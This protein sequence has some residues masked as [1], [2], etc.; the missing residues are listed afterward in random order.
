MPELTFEHT[1]YY[2]TEAAIPAW[3]VAESLLALQALATRSAVAIE[4]LFPDVQVRATTVYVEQLTSGS[5]K[6]LVLIKLLFG[7]QKRLEKAVDTAR[8]AIGLDTLGT[9]HPLLA[10]LILALALDGCEIAVKYWHEK[11][12]LPQI[13]VNQMIIVNAGADALSIPPQVFKAAVDAAAAHNSANLANDA[14]RF[15]QPAKSGPSG[16]LELQESPQFAISPETVQLMPSHILPQPNKDSLRDYDNVEVEIRATDLD[17]TKSGWWVRVP[18]IS[19]K[20]LPME[21]GLDVNPFALPSGARITGNI[22]V[23]FQTKTDAEPLPRKVFLR[24]LVPSPTISHSR[25][26]RRIVLAE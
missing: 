6:E 13:Q 2:R 24:E 26:R 14:L 25:S 3:Q 1:F 12:A 15:I 5:L 17:R 9:K 7:E 16:W 23:A 21:V 20:R 8:E 11:N 19:P 4:K 10:A 22:T 18:S